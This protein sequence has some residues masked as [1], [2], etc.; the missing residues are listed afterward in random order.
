MSDFPGTRPCAH[1]IHGRENGALAEAVDASADPVVFGA[2][3]ASLRVSLS[4][5]SG[6]D[7]CGHHGISDLAF[8]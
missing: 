6:T 2:S 8:H 7:S 5:A 3:G 1:T 4:C